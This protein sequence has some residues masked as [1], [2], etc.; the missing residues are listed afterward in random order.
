MRTVGHEYF[1][2]WAVSIT[3]QPGHIIVEFRWQ[4]THPLAREYSNII[5][6]VNNVG[7]AIHLGPI[8]E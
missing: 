8:P 6:Y 2:R 3:L 7:L 1:L 4:G 5:G